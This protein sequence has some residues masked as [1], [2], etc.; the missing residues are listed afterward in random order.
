MLKWRGI[1]MSGFALSLL[2]HCMTGVTL[3]FFHFQNKLD[4]QSVQIETVFDAEPSVEEFTRDLNQDT[5]VSETLNVVAGG[6]GMGG[7]ALTQASGGTGGV[8]G[9]GGGDAYGVSVAKINGSGQFRDPTI[10]VGLG[11]IGLPGIDQIG[12][13][14]GEGV[15]RGEPTAVVEGYG[16]A[17]GRITQELLRM[18]REEKLLVV[19][20]FDES[21]SMK[22]DQKEIRE[23]FHKVYEE[24]GIAMERDTKSRA[25]KEALLT[26]VHSFGEATHQ[27][28]N[29]PTADIP[30]IRAAIDKI[31]IDKSGLENMFA[32]VNKVLDQYR[33]QA[34]RTHRKLVIIIVTDESGDDGQGPLLDEVVKKA[35]T[36]RVASPV[37]VLGRESVFGYPY[38]RMHWVDPKYG[39]SHWLLINRGPETA[40]PEALQFDGLHDR[41]DAWPAGFAPYEQ[42]RLTKETGGIF[43]VLPHEEQNLDR[44][45]VV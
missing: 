22:D 39:L 45:S 3:A 37:Y 6:G 9:G 34:N 31:E 19:W 43:F 29:K 12:T 13:D 38:A 23:Q 44:K 41:W 42:A 17:L 10:G 4:D 21:E 24:L 33:A 35:T 40:M 18:L 32:A 11:E 26:A 5:E 7:E 36:G 14:L 27:I 30:E 16:A 8:G 25:D 28:T 20:L 15:I 2:L 1:E